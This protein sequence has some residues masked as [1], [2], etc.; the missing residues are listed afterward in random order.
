[1]CCPDYSRCF[2]GHIDP[3][4]HTCWSYNSLKNLNKKYTQIYHI[5]VHYKQ[6]HLDKLIHMQ[7]KRQFGG[8][9]HR[10][11]IA[12]HLYILCAP[13]WPNQQHLGLTGNKIK[14]TPW[15]V[16]LTCDLLFSTRWHIDGHRLIDNLKWFRLELIKTQGLPQWWDTD[17]N[18][19]RDMSL[20]HFLYFG[21]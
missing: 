14:P 5:H 7:L 1:M 21:G 4:M 3:S 19:T 17:F 12:L 18:M 2:Y 16:H 20:C 11:L 13:D 6:I 15:P 9:C 8:A 10:N